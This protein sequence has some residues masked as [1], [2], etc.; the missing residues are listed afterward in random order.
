MSRLRSGRKHFYSVAQRLSS[1]TRP[2]LRLCWSPGNL[3]EAATV[4]P[5]GPHPGVSR[6]A[7]SPGSFPGGSI[8]QT[9]SW[10]GCLFPPRHREREERRRPLPQPVLVESRVPSGRG[11][12]GAGPAHGNNRSLGGGVHPE[13][14]APFPKLFPGPPGPTPAESCPRTP[15]PCRTIS[16]SPLFAGKRLKPSKNRTNENQ[17]SGCRRHEGTSR[18]GLQRH[19]VASMR[20][21]RPGRG[22]TGNTGGSHLA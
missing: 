12:T 21:C 11:P 9:V 20:Q 22:C 2:F 5:T 16:D 8:A 4:V 14:P 1:P 18:P 19:L 3:R 15:K 10:C 17:G 7:W 13:R 6:E